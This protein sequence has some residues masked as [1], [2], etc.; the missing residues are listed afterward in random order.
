MFRFLNQYPLASWANMNSMSAFGHFVCDVFNV[1]PL[2]QMP[3]SWKIKRA[4]AI[5]AG[6]IISD[7]K[8][9]VAG[10]QRVL[11]IGKCFACC[12][13]PGYSMRWSPPPIIVHKAAIALWEMRPNPQPMIPGL[14][15]VSPEPLGTGS[16]FSPAL[17]RV[18]TGQRTKSLS[19]RR[20]PKQAGALFALDSLRQP[21]LS[22]PSVMA[23]IGAEAIWGVTAG[24]P[25]AC[26]HTGATDA[27]K[28][29]GHRETS[30][31]GVI[32]PAVSA[33]RGLLVCAAEGRSGQRPSDLRLVRWPP[34][35][36]V[37]LSKPLQFYHACPIGLA[38]AV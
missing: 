18:L 11:G 4:D 1:C 13:F 38:H 36:P 19:R 6:L 33:A 29:E 15:N 22:S 23:F 20:L 27:G 35:P 5:H 25:S 34:G 12:D 31:L 7:A 2:E 21:L 8:A 14:V 10:V 3:Q 28:L 24:A 30:S 17:P 16:Q 26:E 9:N 32:P 37:K